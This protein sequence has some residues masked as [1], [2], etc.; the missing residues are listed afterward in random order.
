MVK[1]KKGD[2]LL[3]PENDGPWVFDSHP[4]R[5]L[6]AEACRRPLPSARLGDTSGQSDG[7]ARKTAATMA[8]YGVLD[9]IQKD[10]SLSYRL[11]DRWE[12]A[13]KQARLR[14]SKGRLA[15]GQ[16]LFLVKRVSVTPLYRRLAD[17]DQVDVR[18]S[19]VSRLPH[20]PEFGLVIAL[21]QELDEDAVERLASELDD[22][23]VLF[24]RFSL[25]QLV[26][27]EELRKLAAVSL[28]GAFGD[29]P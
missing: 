27:S 29:E 16:M 18:L 7:N 17:R 20:H 9:P 22:A 3:D 23:G 10:G 12:P 25:G 8:E 26:G 13:V 1:H 19:W 14:A 4:P 6:M 2:S 5:L 21:S 11:N 24:E 28:P 15:A